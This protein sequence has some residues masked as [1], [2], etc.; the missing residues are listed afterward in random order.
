MN[1]VILLIP[2]YNNLEGLT[3]SINAIGTNEELDLLIVD[4][5]SSFLLDEDNIKKSFKAKGLV[6]F[7]YLK[8]NQG[9]ENA[10]NVGLT[11][12]LEKGYTYTARLDCG[13]ICVS[14]RFI[15][16][17]SFLNENKDISLIGSD[18]DFVN[19][20]GDFLYKLKVPKE[21]KVIRRKMYI[22]AMHIHPTIMFR[23]SI[24]NKTGLYPTNYKAAEDYAFFFQVL[25]H[26][27]VANLDEVLVHCELNP[28]G[29]S[30]VKRSE[31]A[32]NRVRIIIA[33]F[34]FGVYPI[35]GLLRSLLLC[36]VPLPLLIR[37][38]TILKKS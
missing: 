36:I 32:R 17:I 28:N 5:G 31:Q 10:L 18:V 7:K 21:D 34:Y 33:N 16:Q 14:D 15:K 6:F 4:D 20:K 37:L 38:K 8:A 22:N 13:D 12:I 35:Y 1:N 26:C 24:L 29:L 23:N 27:K 25:Q 19:T 30:A 2:H 9:I 3:K 11:Y